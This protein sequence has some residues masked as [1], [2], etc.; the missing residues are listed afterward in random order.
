MAFG[1]K[2][3]ALRVMKNLTQ[4]ELGERTDLTK[5]YLS[6]LENDQA[7]PTVDTLTDILTVLG[8]SLA[9][10]FTEEPSQ[11]TVLFG[12]DQQVDHVDEGLGY[13]LR[14]LI[15]DSNEREMEPVLLTIEPGGKF[16][17][18]DPSPAETFVYVLKGSV[19]LH[20]GDEVI[21]ARAH[22]S[23]YFTATN[24]HQLTNTTAKPVT[25]LLVATA[26]YL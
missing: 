16:K 21:N 19:G 7:S 22:E 10:F 25:L 17:A 3:R 26:S 4:E 13:H 2:L 24:P 12:M 8:V 20:L 15:N 23:L 11:A 9:E 5:G 14:W 18:F 6:Q 1:Q